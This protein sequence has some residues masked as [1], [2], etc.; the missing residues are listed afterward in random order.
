MKD[1]KVFLDDYRQKVFR[2]EITN[3]N[4]QTEN[5]FAHEALYLLGVKGVESSLKCDSR[6]RRK[7]NLQRR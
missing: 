7:M 1:I 4:H 6:Y 2:K 3:G 5:N